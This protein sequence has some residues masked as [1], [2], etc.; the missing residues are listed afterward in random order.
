[1]RLPAFGARRLVHGKEGGEEAAA[2][3]CNYGYDKQADS[4]TQEGK[5]SEG[6]PNRA[7]HANNSP[8]TEHDRRQHNPSSDYGNNNN[9]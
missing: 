9:G 1:M 6:G 8:S 7:K 3:Y 2:E 4:E 5:A